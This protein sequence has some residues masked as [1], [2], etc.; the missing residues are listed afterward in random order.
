MGACGSMSSPTRAIA[1]R[2]WS[3]SR[4]QSRRPHRL[5]ASNLS[6]MMFS[7]TLASA[8]TWISWWTRPMPRSRQSRQLRT[9]SGAPSKSI[10]PAS[11]WYI[12]VTILSRVL[13]PAPFS[14]TRAWIWPG[15]NESDTSSSAR[16]PGKRLLMDCSSSTNQRG[17]LRYLVSNSPIIRAVMALTSSSKVSTLSLV[18]S[19]VPELMK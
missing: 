9:R 8:T 5:K 12:P 15:W 14:P 16:T 3:S 18:T 17:G 11:G 4:G 13:L 7:A 6:S 2:A 1:A 10:R 19:T